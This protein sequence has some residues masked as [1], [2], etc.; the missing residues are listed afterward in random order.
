MGVTQPTLA[1]VSFLLR[2]STADLAMVITSSKI[3]TRNAGPIST[4]C[5]CQREPFAVTNPVPRMGRNGWYE[6]ARS[7][8]YN[9]CFV[10]SGSQ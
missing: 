4:R 2:R 5:V 8:S 1:R 10:C 7:F 6:N 9:R 3:S